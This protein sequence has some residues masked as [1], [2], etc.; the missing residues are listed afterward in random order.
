ML[1]INNISILLNIS[2]DSIKI[3]D[4]VTSEDRYSIVIVRVVDRE[5]YRVIINRNSS[6]YDNIYSVIF[7]KFVGF[8]ESKL[9]YNVN[10]THDAFSTPYEFIN[11]LTRVINKFNEYADNKKL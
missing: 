6:G 5:S 4:V 9:K 7:S 8:K 11:W 3:S 10:V 1:V 2:N